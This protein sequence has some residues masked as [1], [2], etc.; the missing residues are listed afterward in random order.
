MY[1]GSSIEQASLRVMFQE[2]S[3]FESQLFTD[4]PPG[5]ISVGFLC[6]YGKIPL[7]CLY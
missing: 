2:D 1:L 6:S 7:R 3:W 5:D 4:Y